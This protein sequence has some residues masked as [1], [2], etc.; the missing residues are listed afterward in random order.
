MA[1][2]LGFKTFATGDVLT[3]GDTNGYL[4]Q[5]V[6]VFAS[7]AARTSA[8]AS[9]QEG[10]MSFLKDTNSTEYYDGAAWQTVGAASGGMTSLASGSIAAAVTGVDISS[11]SSA[12]NE[13]ILYVKA[14][15]INSTGKLNVRFN[16]DSGANYTYQFSTGGAF[17]SS[18]GA[19]ELVL[20]QNVDA[21]VVANSFIISIPNYTD[22]TSWKNL[23]Y[24]GSQSDSAS[25]NGGGLWKST[26]AINRLSFATNGPSFDGGTYQL[27]G[28]K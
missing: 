27:F 12:Y 21:A 26:S 13:L 15:S 1:A 14:V 18:S 4:M 6:L 24:I 9:P 5:G 3:A 8:I 2:G 7:A 11:I 22:T 17:T 25:L 23:S 16:N 19:T 28:V 10:Q 20:T